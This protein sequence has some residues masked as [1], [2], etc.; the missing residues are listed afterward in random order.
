MES[1]EHWY[2]KVEK[3]GM[4]STERWSC[5]GPKQGMKST[6]RRSCTCQ[7]EGM[8]STEPRSCKGMES[9]ERRSCN[10]PRKGMESIEPRSGKGMEIS[11]SIWCEGH[12]CQKHTP[13][14]H[15][16]RTVQQTRGLGYHLRTFRSVRS[17]QSP[18]LLQAL[19][20][21]CPRKY[22]LQRSVLRPRLGT[23][24][25]ADNS[26]LWRKSGTRRWCPGF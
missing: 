2:C 10:G 17:W 1:T 7:K 19:L 5:K 8:K 3:Q 13:Q 22:G 24:T 25:R 12:L 6:E 4:E 16:K 20:Q 21:L 11:E 18:C 26:A 15:A 23:G 9:I 14:T